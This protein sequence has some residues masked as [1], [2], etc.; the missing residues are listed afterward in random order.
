MANVAFI[1][2]D[3]FEDSEFTEPWQW[4]RDAGHQ[5]TVIGLRRGQSINAAILASIWWA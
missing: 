3:L 4:A 1:L 5:T 2:A